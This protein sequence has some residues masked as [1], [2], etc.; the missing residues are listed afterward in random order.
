MK[1]DHCGKE[2][3][4]GNREDGLPNGVGFVTDDGR[5]ITLCSDCL[6]MVGAM[7]SRERLEFYK[8]LFMEKQS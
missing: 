4:S 5:H 8:E 6:M 7:P 1:C 3:E 2:F